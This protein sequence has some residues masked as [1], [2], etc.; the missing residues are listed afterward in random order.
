[1]RRHLLGS[2][3]ALLLLLLL[4]AGSCGE[5]EPCDEV[6]RFSSYPARPVEE[7]CKPGTPISEN[8]RQSGSTTDCDCPRTGGTV[9]GVALCNAAGN[10]YERFIVKSRT[11]TPNGRVD[12]RRIAQLA[13]N[14]KR[15]GTTGTPADP[16]RFIDQRIVERAGL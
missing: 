10:A 7:C 14:L 8:P 15:I 16:T 3:P 5:P 11:P 6:N 12:P 9:D 1:M 4:S 2:A 13:D